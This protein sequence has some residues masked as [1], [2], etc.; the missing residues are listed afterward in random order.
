[1]T[2]TIEAMTPRER[3][4]ARVQSTVGPRVDVIE[5]E[6]EMTL[7]CY[8]LNSDMV[9]RALDNIGDIRRWPRFCVLLAVAM[10][11][12]DEGEAIRDIKKMLRAALVDDAM[13]SVMRDL[14]LNKSEMPQ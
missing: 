7:D 13:D 6:V 9:E 10:T 4:Q 2:F 12:I 8:L 5:R 1:M 3:S 11:G 14:G